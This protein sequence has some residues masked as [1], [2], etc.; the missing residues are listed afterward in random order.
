MKAP[1]IAFLASLAALS[2][3]FGVAVG[4]YE[5]FPYKYLKFVLNSVEAVVA[6]RKRLTTN[7]PTGFISERRYDG[8]GVTIH[9]A[10]RSDSGVTLLSGFF[11][12]LPEVRLIRMDGSVIRRWPIS[13]MT[14]YP[15]SD[16]IF[17]KDEVPASDLN[18]AVHGMEITPD[19]SIVF[20]LDGKGTTKLDRCGNVVWTL[21]RMT[22]HSID[23]SADGTYWIPSRNIVE[24]PGSALP[25]FKTPYR[26][27]TIL[28]VSP[29]GE[30]LS[31]TSVH[32]ILIDNGLFALI[33]ANGAFKTEVREY[34]ALH[35]ND[36]EEL[37][38][39]HAGSFPLFDAGDLVL[40]LRH[41]NLVFVV[42]PDDWRVKWYQSGPWLRQHDADFLPDGT[43]SVYNNNSDD[44]DRGDILKGSNIMTV[45]PNAPGRSTQ[46]VFGDKEGQSFFT[47][48]QGKHQLLDNGNTLVA[49]YFPGRAFE[50]DRNGD[51][52]WQYLNVYNDEHAAKISGANR[53]PESYFEVTDWTCPSD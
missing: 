20:N 5:I 9:D 22:H 33:V 28:R 37:S 17:P 4:A 21:A 19:G 30:V 2:F 14:L 25:K 40:S 44:T 3:A 29:D 7:L 51:I 47:N 31:E 11:E 32:K 8:E 15:N 1:F 35:V 16:H 46:I 49:E 26:D 27:D 39:E 41:L 52:V 34:D 12:E 43:I 38:A 42:D 50:Y 10:E 45:D 24:D 6:D 36:I 48:T 13:Y 23:K 18:A 53:Y